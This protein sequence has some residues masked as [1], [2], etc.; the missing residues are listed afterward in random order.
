[1]TLGTKWQ[2]HKT[3]RMHSSFRSSR[4]CLVA[5]KAGVVTV[6]GGLANVAKCGTPWDCPSCSSAVRAERTEPIGVVGQILGGMCMVTLTSPHLVQD[7]LADVFDHLTKS[8]RA[9]VS[10][11]GAWRASW[12]RAVEVTHGSS[13]W[14]PHIHVIVF[15]SDCESSGA[16]L[17]DR[18]LSVNPTAKRSAQHVSPTVDPAYLGKVGA[19]LSVPHSNAE[20]VDG[21]SLWAAVASGARKLDVALEFESVVRGRKWLTWSRNLKATREEAEEL[22]AAAADEADVPDEPTYVVRAACWN[23]ALDQCRVDEL[24]QWAADHLLFLEKY[25]GLPEDQIPIWDSV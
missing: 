7:S 16:G 3:R 19:E 25:G 14:H 1:M 21:R 6:R 5:P 10:G 9:T 8:W 23:R 17:V 12:V 22:I 24:V 2:A 11:R 13:G 18:W 20:R 15:G 4:C